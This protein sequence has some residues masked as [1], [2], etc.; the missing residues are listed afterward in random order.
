MRKMT[1][2]AVCMIICLMS[3][4]AERRERVN[5]VDTSG[6]VTMYTTAYNLHGVTATGGTTRP[7]IAACN[8]HIGEVAIIYTLDGQF[9]DMVEITDTGATDG[10]RTGNVIDVWFDTYEECEKWMVETGGRVKVLFVKGAG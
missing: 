6:M 4:G 1:I 7:H 9:L 3:C 2:I 8:P 10:L 5:A